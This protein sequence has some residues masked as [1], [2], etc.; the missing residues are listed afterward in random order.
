MTNPIVDPLVENIDS[1]AES[2]LVRIEATLDGAATVW[3]NRPDRENALDALTVAALSEAF[4][5]LRG[6]EGVRIVFLRGVGGHFSA[7]ADLGWVG[8]TADLTED[9]NREDAFEVAKML[10][11]LYDLPTLTVA[12]V[13]GVAFG[14][15]AGLVAAQ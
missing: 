4:A 13:D 11:A 8:D 9:E 10:K 5:T 15:G 3:I 12:L 14:I 6:A 7:G 1:D 2:A